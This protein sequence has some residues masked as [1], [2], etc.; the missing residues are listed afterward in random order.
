MN[1]EQ[2]LVTNL[3]KEH[4]NIHEQERI[5]DQK[6]KDEILKT[7]IIDNIIDISP[8]NESNFNH[9]EKVCCEKI[10]Q[11]DSMPNVNPCE[12]S[13]EFCSL[14]ENMRN[15]SMKRLNRIVDRS[16]KLSIPLKQYDQFLDILGHLDPDFKEQ[17]NKIS[18]YPDKQKEYIDDYVSSKFS[19]IFDKLNMFAKFLDLLKK[20]S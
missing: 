4:I 3:I 8:E 7:L 5:T 20:D 12:I 6:E 2:D 15:T 10:K 16:M 18:Y 1:N 19:M 13:E 9:L 14:M 11:L 17:I